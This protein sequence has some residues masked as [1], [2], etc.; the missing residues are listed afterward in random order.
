MMREMDRIVHDV[1]FNTNVE[2]AVLADEKNLNYEIGYL[3]PDYSL[4]PLVELDRVRAVCDKRLSKTSNRNSGYSI[5]EGGDSDSRKNGDFAIFPGLV[6]MSMCVTGHN[7]SGQRAEALANVIK[8]HNCISELHMG[9][10]QLCG[11]D[12]CAIT[13]ALGNNRTIH[14]LDLRLNNI[15]RT[16]A[17][18]IA[19][20][21]QKTKCLQLLNL[22]SSNMDLASI[23]IVMSAAA[24]NRTLTDLDLSFLDVSDECCEC[25]RDMLKVNSSLQKLRLRNNNLMWSGCY[26][27]AE[28]LVRNMGLSVLDLSGNTVGDDGVQVSVT[29]KTVF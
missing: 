20:L 9:K 11:K 18:A 14:S 2:N 6:M 19:E 10:T 27:L 13:E 22:S 28:G 8:N 17:V 26:V 5:L 24:G 1:A 4:K 3:A 7:L 16:G 21:L 25:L 15:D 29:Y 23:K 12:I